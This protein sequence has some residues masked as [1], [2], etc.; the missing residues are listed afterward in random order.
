[1]NIIKQNQIIKNEF[2]KYLNQRSIN[3]LII[4][5]VSLENEKL[6]LYCY[7]FFNSL[8]VGIYYEVIVQND[9]LITVIKE[10]TDQTLNSSERKQ[11]EDLAK[12]VLNRLNEI[13]EKEDLK[14]HRMKLVK[15]ITNN[16]FEI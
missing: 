2:E 4:D 11:I 3:N 15:A 13:N 9:E 16:G 14:L 10:I 6:I 7:I 5:F 1:M 12:F 8:R